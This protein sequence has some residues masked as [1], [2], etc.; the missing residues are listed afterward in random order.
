MIDAAVTGRGL[1]AL[2]AAAELAEL[3]LR[4]E[5][6]GGP[7]DSPTEPQRDI[8]GALGALMRRLAGPI[9]GTARGG[10]PAAAPRFFPPATTLLQTPR[11]AWAPLPSPSVAG[12]PAVPLAAESLALL[13]GRG[14]LR[15]A[16]DRIAPV[17]TVGKTREIGVL[18]R[19]RLG[20]PALERMVAPI[21]RDRFGVDPDRIEAAIAVPGLNEALTRAGSLSGAALALSERDRDRETRVRPRD[22]WVALSE[23]LEHRLRA[24]DVRFSG[25]TITELRRDGE[26]WV[27]R[28]EDGTTVAARSVIVDAGD[29]VHA[30]ARGHS[31][32]GPRAG[33]LRLHRRRALIT[34]GPQ[35]LEREGDAA[36][37]TTLVHGRERWSLRLEREADEAWRVALTGP[38]I[39]AEGLDAAERDT[40][41]VHEL[42]ESALRGLGAAVDP[43]DR[44]C[45]QWRAAAA[46]TVDERTRFERYRLEGEPGDH[47]RLDVGEMLYGDD[48][49]A[50]VAAASGRAVRL[51]RRLAGITE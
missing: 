30:D 3:G 14:A 40:P 21:L 23:A 48:L 22:G 37:I 35:L 41:G 47:P 13:G 25:T 1:P 10:S 17:L 34:P 8:A 46:V 26:G 15:A 12:I 5:V 19:R 28:A 7:A 50:A 51:R 18:V 4:V 39:D 38:R 45:G 20:T 27:L 9:P 16:R 11:G 43:T 29:R 24:Y 32:P 49:S 36:A 2:V 6:F 31:L 33:H 44:W 42:A